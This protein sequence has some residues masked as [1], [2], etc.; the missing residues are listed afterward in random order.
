MTE[1][2]LLIAV[3]KR[4]TITELFP[5]V[6]SF[7]LDE[8]GRREM[9]TTMEFWT[10]VKPIFMQA[11]DLHSKTNDA[12]HSSTMIVEFLKGLGDKTFK[13]EDAELM[14]KACDAKLLTA[15]P[16][17]MLYHM[18]SIC[19]MNIMR[20]VGK[21]DANGIYQIS[22]NLQ[23]AKT[24][25]VYAGELAIA[26]SVLRKYPFIRFD[27]YRFVNFNIHYEGEVDRFGC[28]RISIDGYYNI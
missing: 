25:I 4:Q 23:A 5:I 18:R 24:P 14:A 2:Q 27:I 9:R 20:Y 15:T 11:A 16:F 3:P 7:Q 8:I 10:L 22:P 17:D 26:G 28:P 1:D 21:M 13:A 6:E 19:F 12:F